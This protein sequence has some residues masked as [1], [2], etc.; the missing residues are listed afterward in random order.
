[1]RRIWHPYWAWEDYERGLYADSETFDEH[2]AAAADLLANP[3]ALE[4]AMRA[5]VDA[6][7][8]SAEHN[9][10]ADVGRRSWLGQAACFYKSGSPEACTRVAWW[11]LTPEQRDLA[12]AAADRVAD[13]YEKQVDGAQTLF[14]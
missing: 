1:M 11:T 8:R 14:S 13:D 10:T 12:N 9:L 2:M 7:P 3:V 6:Y 5:A 4:A